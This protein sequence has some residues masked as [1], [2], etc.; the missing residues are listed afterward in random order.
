VLFLPDTQER[1][2]AASLWNAE[3]GEFKKLEGTDS[4][5]RGV[6]SPDSDFVLMYSK[7]QSDAFVYSVTG[8][9]RRTALKHRQNGVERAIFL[10]GRAFTQTKKGAFL[11]QIPGFY[12]QSDAAGP[13][14]T[15]EKGLQL[16]ASPGKQ[17]AL[18][19]QPTRPTDAQRET[20]DVDAVKLW[21]LGADGKLVLDQTWPSDAWMSG[22]QSASDFT[23]YSPDDHQLLLVRNRCEED[24]SCIASVWDFWTG[25]QVLRGNLRKRQK[26]QSVALWPAG[27][28]AMTTSLHDKTL[29]LW[30][31]GGGGAGA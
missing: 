21:R 31:V 29:K 7:W 26:V 11:W 25:H 10:D 13:G 1:D 15:L 23:L 20:Q 28:R 5:Y 4:K 2:A 12:A 24:E 27:R 30:K 17:H 22:I 16:I 14:A 3:D 9:G 19:F 18:T 8:P 6:F